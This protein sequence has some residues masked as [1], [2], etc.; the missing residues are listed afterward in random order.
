M[1]VVWGVMLL[2]VFIWGAEKI[3]VDPLLKIK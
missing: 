1:H 3:S 2:A